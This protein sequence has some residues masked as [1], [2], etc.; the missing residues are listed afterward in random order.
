MEF[1]LEILQH[2]LPDLKLGSLRVSPLYPFKTVEEN[3]MA[4]PEKNPWDEKLC[5][6]EFCHLENVCEQGDGA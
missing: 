5:T 1:C 6:S 3:A 2:F 4:Y